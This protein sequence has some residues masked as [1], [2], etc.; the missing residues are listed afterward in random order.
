MI[1]FPVRKTGPKCIA[2]VGLMAGWLAGRL[3][4]KIWV[5]FEIFKILERF[6]YLDFYFITIIAMWLIVLEGHFSWLFS[7]KVY[8]GFVL[9]CT[10]FSCH[11]F[12]CWSLLSSTSILND[13][14]KKYEHNYPNLSIHN[15]CIPLWCTAGP[16]FLHYLYTHVFL[17]EK[18]D[19]YVHIWP[20]NLRA[21]FQ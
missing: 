10:K 7:N 1:V 5:D 15:V 2:L 9:R 11:F 18:N 19:K 14:S 3:T 12:S 6:N 16:L 21:P 17:S 13:N 4:D 20:R 8:L